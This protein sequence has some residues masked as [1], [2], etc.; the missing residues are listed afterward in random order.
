MSLTVPLD[1]LPKAVLAGKSEAALLLGITWEELLPEDRMVRLLL[2]PNPPEP[3]VP[4]IQAFMHEITRLNLLENGT[5]KAHVTPPMLD[6]HR[7]ALTI[8]GNTYAVAHRLE[9]SWDYFRSTH[10]V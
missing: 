10:R 6:I 8:N 4:V 7:A 9:A 2:V 1:E 3:E 5:L